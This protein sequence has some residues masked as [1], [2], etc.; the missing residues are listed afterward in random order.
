MERLKLIERNQIV[1]VCRRGRERQR[2]AEVPDA[3]A[4]LR[5]EPIE[6]ADDLILNRAPAHGH[7]ADGEVPRRDGVERSWERR[8]RVAATC[9]DPPRGGGDEIGER[10]AHTSL[11][12]AQPLGPRTPVD[13]EP[14]DRARPSL[15]R[16]SAGAMVC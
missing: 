13:D 15:P 6:C 2:C 5:A 8:G 7:A 4:V 16:V 9:A 12:A 10:V 3:D 11:E 1:A 14:R